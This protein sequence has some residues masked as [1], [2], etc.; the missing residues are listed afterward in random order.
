[1]TAP[2]T[3]RRDAQVWVNAWTALRVD[4]DGLPEGEFREWW[5][6]V[7]SAVTLLRDRLWSMEN[8]DLPVTLPIEAAGILAMHIRN[9]HRFDWHI[10]DEMIDLICR[11]G[12]LADEARDN[13]ALLDAQAA[14]AARRAAMAEAAE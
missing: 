4:D 10:Y 5:T 1:M 7:D 11:F 13:E 2:N 6:E 9:P 14:E 8:D 3:P 12:D